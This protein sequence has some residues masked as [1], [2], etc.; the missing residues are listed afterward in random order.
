MDAQEQGVRNLLKLVTFLIYNLVVVV[1][2]IANLSFMYI[3]C[4]YK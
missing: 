4:V 3:E 2:V 1:V